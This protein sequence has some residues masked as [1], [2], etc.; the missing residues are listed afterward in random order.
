MC[1]DAKLIAIM[2]GNPTAKQQMMFHRPI[3][4]ILNLPIGLCG[5]LGDSSRVGFDLQAGVCAPLHYSIS[6]HTI[7]TDEVKQMQTR[8]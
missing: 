7:V 4:H 5:P 8:V 2:P 3:F 1:A 6:I